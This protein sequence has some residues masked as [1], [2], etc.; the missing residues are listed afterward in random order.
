MTQTVLVTGAN[1]Y[2]AQHVILQ[3][4]NAGY[5]VV[6]SL[7][8]T[9][10]GADLRNALA[11]HLDAAPD[12]DQLSFVALDLLSD[13]GWD[14]AMRDVDAVLHTASPVPIRKLNDPQD[15]IRPAVDGALRAVK[16]AHA[17]GVD[18]LVLTSSIAAIM[19]TDL[20]PDQSAYDESNWTDPARPDVAPYS[21]SKT[22]AE[23]AV[24]DWQAEN[25]PE[26]KITAIN[27]AF[28]MGPP[29]TPRISSSLTLV[30]RLMIGKGPMLPR[31]G[32]TGVDVRDIAL[33]HLRAL[34][35]PESAG[36]RFIGAERFQWFSEMAEQLKAAFP[37]RRIVTRTAPNW[38]IRVMARFDP[39]LKLVV[40]SLGRH[41]LLSAEAARDVLGIEFR[42]AADAFEDSAHYLVKHGLV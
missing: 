8:D 7:R 23:R 26:M 39:T 27:P 21:Q 1:G 17:A 42:S 5:R 16:A 20:R 31:I 35:R 19:G 6:G 32:F 2:I 22:L 36:R 34:E 29:I 13:D 33:M 12:N 10:G 4:L 41:D 18:R 30:K 14:T 11:P 28:V 9:A 25:A 24:W 3:L 40:N 15:V 38:L 37:E